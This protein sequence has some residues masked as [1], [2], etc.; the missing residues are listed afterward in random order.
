MACQRLNNYFI[1][2]YLIVS[3]WSNKFFNIKTWF[4]HFF[5]IRCRSRPQHIH[6]CTWGQG[7]II[8]DFVFQFSAFKGSRLMKFDELESGMCALLYQ[9]AF[10]SINW[11]LNLTLRIEQPGK[12]HSA[13][14]SRSIW[15]MCQVTFTPSIFFPFIFLDFSHRSRIHSI[16]NAPRLE[17]TG[18]FSFANKDKWC[19]VLFMPC[20]TSQSVCSFAKV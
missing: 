7:K 13:V 8:H 2:T 6:R 19:E 16:Q 3:S 1:W 15:I 11:F 4:N 20:T 10:I 12:N 5:M 14:P 9:D 17:Q 18:S